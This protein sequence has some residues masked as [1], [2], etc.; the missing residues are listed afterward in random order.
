MG[1]Y[2]VQ[3]G[4]YGKPWFPENSLKKIFLNFFLE[5]V[6]HYIMSSICGKNFSPIGLTVSEISKS[7]KRGGV[8]LS[9]LCTL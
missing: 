8:P 6:S 4:P 5:H 9:K 3:V 7:S 2:G 1:S